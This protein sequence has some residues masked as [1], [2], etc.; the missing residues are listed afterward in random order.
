[1]EG[2]ETLIIV[3]ERPNVTFLMAYVLLN[4]LEPYSMNL[5]FE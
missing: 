3:V 5:C 1:M 2:T 4:L